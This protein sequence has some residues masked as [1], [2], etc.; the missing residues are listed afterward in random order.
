ML[1]TSSEPDLLPMSCHFS[2][3]T[4]HSHALP[5]RMC[6]DLRCRD[7][8]FAPRAD[9]YV[10]GLPCQP[11]S[12]AGDR[13]GERCPDGQLFPKMLEYLSHHRPTAYV[14]ENV[15]GS[16]EFSLAHL[17]LCFAWYFCHGKGSKSLL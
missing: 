9:L 15:V 16:M 11:Y 10:C 7:A 1:P 3:A 17:G 5:E 14:L 6:H 12:A 2:K 4:L 13:E 8:R